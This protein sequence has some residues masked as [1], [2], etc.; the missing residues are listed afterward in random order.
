MCV[1]G[2]GAI[3]GA[4]SVGEGPLPC[5]LPRPLPGPCLLCLGPGSQEH[6]HPV[7]ERPGPSGAFLGGSMGPRG[8]GEALGAG[9]GAGLG[10]GKVGVRLLLGSPRCLSARLFLPTKLASAWLPWHMRRNLSLGGK[11]GERGSGVREWKQRGG[12]SVL[13]EEKA[14]QPRSSA[15]GGML[16]GRGRFR[17]TERHT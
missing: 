5:A 16:T 17:V 15:R 2:G 13:G 11:P 9:R 1:R 12:G 14:K 10:V 4:E 3:P 8:R 6:L 7:Q